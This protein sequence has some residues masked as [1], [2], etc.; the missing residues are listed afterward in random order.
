MAGR[1]GRLPVLAH[2][3]Y[4]RWHATGATWGAARGVTRGGRRR[5]CV[6]DPRLPTSE[7]A[8]IVDGESGAAGMALNLLLCV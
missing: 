1:T 7:W 5:A 2:G 8:R 3:L 6:I 4:Q